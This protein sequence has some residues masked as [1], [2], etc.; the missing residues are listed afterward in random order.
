MIKFES[1]EVEANDHLLDFMN[2]VINKWNLVE[3]NRNELGAAIHT[4]QLYIIMHMLQREGA[5]GF[6]NWYD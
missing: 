4:L 2:I 6:S 3:G 5:E 1:E